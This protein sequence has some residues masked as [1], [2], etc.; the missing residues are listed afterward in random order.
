MMPR[1]AA[2]A[3]VLLAYAAVLAA[4]SSMQRSLLYPGVGRRRRRPTPASPISRTSTSTTPD[5]ERLVGWWKP[6][7][8]GRRSIL[9]FHGNGGRLWTAA[10]ASPPHAGRAR[11]PARRAIGAIRARPARPTE[12]GLAR[13]PR[14]LRLSR[15]STSRPRSCS[16]ASPSE[17]ASRC[18][19]RP[20]GPSAASSSTRPSPRPP[21][22]R[23]RSYWFLPV[24]WLMR[25]QFRSVDLIGA[26]GAAPVLHGDADGIIP[27]RSAS[28]S[29]AAP[30]PKRFV[31]LGPGDTRAFSRRRL[32]AVDEF[33]AATRRHIRSSVA[34]RTWRQRAMTTIRLRAR[35]PGDRETVVDLIQILNLPRPA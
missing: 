1:P 15:D 4:L 12:A 28:A 22:W 17:R 30:E 2:V 7:Q 31:R 9:Y 33:L 34:A 8:P 19:S 32:T 10:T 24:A 14:R 23:A 5:G 6:P 21:T 20:S 27:S 3:A 26:Q 25:D 13:R 18:G 29:R 35:P 16:T 11:P